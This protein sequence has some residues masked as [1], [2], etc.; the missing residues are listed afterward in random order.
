MSEL[1]NGLDATRFCRSKDIHLSSLLSSAFLLRQNLNLPTHK[2][3]TPSSKPSAAHTSG[4]NAAVRS[5]QPTPLDLLALS[6]DGRSLPIGIHGDHHRGHSRSARPAMC[7][8]IWNARAGARRPRSRSS[9]EDPGGL[10]PNRRKFPLKA[11][12][13]CAQWTSSGPAGS[14]RNS[15][16]SSS[17]ARTASASASW[18]DSKGLSQT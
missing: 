8:G 18:S 2:P 15:I 12:T 13:R 11:D 14:G 6:G 1:F 7:L 17:R 9:Q 3:T 10:R 5:A 4:P 16:D